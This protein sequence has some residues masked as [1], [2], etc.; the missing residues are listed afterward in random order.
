MTTVRAPEGSGRLRFRRLPAT[1]RRTVLR[2]METCRACGD[3]RL[4]AIALGRLHRAA[5]LERVLGPVNRLFGRRGPGPQER[6]ERLC[7]TMRHPS[8]TGLCLGR[9]SGPRRP[10]G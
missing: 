7:S 1:D 9:S 2:V 4:D 5:A 10:A 8:R 6:M 3:P